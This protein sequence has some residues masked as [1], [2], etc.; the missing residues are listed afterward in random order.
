MQVLVIDVG[1][2]HVKLFATSA[3]EPRGFASHSGLTAQAMVEQTLA[4][5]RDWEYEAVSLGIP[6]AIGPKGPKAEPGNLG[7][8]WVDFDYAA[9]FGK[10]VRIAN[11]AVLQALG[12]YN[13]GRMLF[14]GLGTGLGSALISDHV[15]IPLELGSLS[16]DERATLAECV[17]R[18]G[19]E[20][21]G[22]AR[23]QAA[24]E[25]MIAQ[26]HSAF[27]T[28]DIVLGGGNAEQVDP[29]PPYTRRGGN[30]D[31]FKGGIMLWD[32]M[33]KPHDDAS[34]GIWKV[35]E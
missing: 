17:G 5:T 10:P 11:D 6:G 15:A 18:A 19:R 34:A 7:T 16:F 1:G 30:G 26:L 24:V 29:L 8:G 13:G 20:R 35:V 25:R 2:S 23:W 28:D 22:Q 9:A 27:L 4:A 21:L 31:A 14:L 12:A 33:D 32:A 3:G